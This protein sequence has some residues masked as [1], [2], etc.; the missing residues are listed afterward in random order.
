MAIP[1]ISTGFGDLVDR[2]VTKLFYDTY[3]ELPDVIPV[4]F[5]M[6][7]SSDQYETASS[8]GALGDFTQFTGQVQY[9]DQFQGY[10]VTATHIEFAS[11][12]QIERALYDD[13][14]HGLW[15]KKPT[16]LA[17]AANRTRQKHAARV[18][19]NAGSIDTFFYRNSENVALVSDSHTTTSGAST[20][21]G[22]DN[23]AT[24]AFSA[25]ALL[26]AVIQMRNFRDDMGNRIEVLPDEIWIPPDLYGTAFEV[27][28]SFGKTA[29][30]NN[31]RNVHYGGYNIMPSDGGWNYMSDA[32]DWFLCESSARKQNLIW[33]ERVPLEFAQAE[34][35]D[36]LV[37]KWR[38]YMRYS[39]AHYDWRWC[40]GS[41][42]S[43]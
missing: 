6:E 19:V 22:F 20:A 3:D 40:M 30:A 24:T 1:M 4:L 33:Y 39:Y 14:R 10:D 7:S 15:E 37:A 38:A 42:V 5:G 41:I 13:D 43:G 27:I 25:A 2:R 17:K 32:T 11:G 8:V 35:I 9:Q 29:G 36:T 31:E 21:V 28:E 12:I 26:A 16:S 34:D 18:W 23:K